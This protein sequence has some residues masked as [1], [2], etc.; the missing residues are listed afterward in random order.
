MDTSNLQY[1]MKVK[2]TLYDN[3]AML[4]TPKTLSYTL[5]TPVKCPYS[6]LLRNNRI[7]P[8]MIGVCL[9]DPS[10]LVL[11]AIPNGGYRV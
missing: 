5:H 10:E 4:K 1:T 6:F 3:N 8:Q 9:I 11:H 7:N 2:K